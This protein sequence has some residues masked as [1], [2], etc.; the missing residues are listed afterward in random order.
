MTS[1]ATVQSEIDLEEMHKRFAKVCESTGTDN[2]LVNDY[3]YL[4]NMGDEIVWCDS[5]CPEPGM[6]VKDAVKY[7]RVDH[8]I[9]VLKDAL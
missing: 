2:E 4:I 5:P 6:E 7:V 9:S 1:R 8:L 3:I